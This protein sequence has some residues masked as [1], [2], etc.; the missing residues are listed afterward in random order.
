[1]NAGTVGIQNLFSKLYPVGVWRDVVDESGFYQVYATLYGIPFDWAIIP[2]LPEGLVQPELHLPFELGKVWS[3]T[4]G[5]HSAW[6]NGSAWAAL[7]FAPPGNA[8]GCVLSNEWITA[9][10]DGLIVRSENGEV[11][12]DLDMD[13]HEQT[14]WVILYLHVESRDRIEEGVYVRKGD[15]LGHP[16][17]EGGV[18]TGTHLHLARKYNGSWISADGDLPFVLDRWV[19][20]GSGIAYD[21]FLSRERVVREACACRNADNQI[22]R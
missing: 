12:L 13:G 21:G 18:S 9:V 16:S 3:Y 15:R 10:A 11:L 17:C 19:S 7:D 22:W 14:G 20:S 1:M 2:L 4:G 5:P 8:L 6:G